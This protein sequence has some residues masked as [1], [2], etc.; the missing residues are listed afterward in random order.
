MLPRLGAYKPA[1]LEP[2]GLPSRTGLIAARFMNRF[3][4][5]LL[6][7]V[8]LPGQLLKRN[9]DVVTQVRHFDV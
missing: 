8:A 7:R 2:A 1:I 4:T 9:I 5:D 3:E 6:T